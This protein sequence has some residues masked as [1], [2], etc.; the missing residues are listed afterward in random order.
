VGNL[1]VGHGK[2]AGGPRVQQLTTGV[3]VDVQ[4]ALTPQ[5]PVH[6]DRVTD[7]RDAVFAEHHSDDT[8]GLCIV[9]KR[10]QHTVDLAG[11]RCRLWRI[12]AVALQVVVQVRDV[13][14]G[15][16]MIR[17]DHSSRFND[18]A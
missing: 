18:P 10:R 17:H 14:Q 6:V 12:W 2:R 15:Q 8:G 11:S 1:V 4:Q 3:G 9:E 16:I 5:C 7:G 13:H